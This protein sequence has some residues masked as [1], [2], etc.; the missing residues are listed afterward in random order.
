MLLSY[1]GESYIN[2]FTQNIKYRN[3]ESTIVV[4]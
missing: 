3:P 4:S 1:E 2:E